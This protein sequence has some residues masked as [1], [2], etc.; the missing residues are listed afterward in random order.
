[1]E[2]K[3]TVKEFLSQG[4][5]FVDGDIIYTN[6]SYYRVV[7]DTISRV[8]AN[9]RVDD[10]QSV[11]VY[12][13]AL[14]IGGSCTKLS[15]KEGGFSAL[16]EAFVE[17]ENNTLYGEY[18][19][20][21]KP[22]DKEEVFKYFNNGLSLYKKVETVFCPMEDAYEAY[23]DFIDESKCIYYSDELSYFVTGVD[24]LEV[25]FINLCRAVVDAYDGKGE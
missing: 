13:S 12:A 14:N 2:N 17:Y 1:M 24:K 11:V 22:L 18:S 9:A 16:S 25:S 7:C 6:T 3:T 5:K 23:C 20:G 21:Y 15:F 10:K 19:I 8:E 4:L